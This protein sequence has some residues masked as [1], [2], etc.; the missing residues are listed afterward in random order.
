MKQKQKEKTNSL[1]SLVLHERGKL[2]RPLG[3]CMCCRCAKLR[4]DEVFLDDSNEYQHF[5]TL[6]N[7]GSGLTIVIR[8]E[9]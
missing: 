4:G 9:N 8:N 1:M 6:I 2:D 7:L 3:D 5:K